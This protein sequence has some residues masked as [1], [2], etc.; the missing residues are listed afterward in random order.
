MYF[1]SNISKNC[2]EKDALKYGPKDN[3]ALRN[4]IFNMS[5]N[6]DNVIP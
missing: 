4:T 6:N 1:V 2:M 3:L 5:K